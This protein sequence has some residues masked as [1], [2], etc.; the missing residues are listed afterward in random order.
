MP[1]RPTPPEARN[2]PSGIIDSVG[3][4]RMSSRFTRSSWAKS[5]VREKIPIAPSRTTK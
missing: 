2:P 4:S 5:R 1:H 3:A